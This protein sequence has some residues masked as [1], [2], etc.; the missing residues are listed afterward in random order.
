VLLK[1]IAQPEWIAAGVVLVASEDARHMT[2]QV[3]TI[4]GRYV[5]D[6]SLRGAENLT[7]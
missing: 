2:G 6:G 4:D 7:E 5:I 1:E 3:L